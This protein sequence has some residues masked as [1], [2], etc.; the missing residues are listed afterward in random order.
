MPHDKVMRNLEL[1][2][3]KVMPYLP[4]GGA[5]KNVKPAEIP[6]AG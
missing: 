4:R 5:T 2:A 1:F 3:D 6:H